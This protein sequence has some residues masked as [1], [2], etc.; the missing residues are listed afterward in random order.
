MRVVSAS[1]ACLAAAFCLAAVPL[2]AQ[3]DSLVSPD[4]GSS[5]L[6]VTSFR[7]PGTEQD[8]GPKIFRL[9]RTG[10]ISLVAQGQAAGERYPQLGWPDAT[11]D[12]LAVAFSGSRK[13]S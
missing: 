8:L 10:A 12:G 5:V 7:Q 6:F 4:D 3:F 11:G 1:R 13:R 9:D 2:R